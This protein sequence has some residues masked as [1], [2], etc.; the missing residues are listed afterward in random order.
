M[1]VQPDHADKSC[2]NIFPSSAFEVVEFAEDDELYTF[3]GLM[4]E[5][6]PCRAQTPS[7]SSTPTRSAELRTQ[8]VPLLKRGRS[9]RADQFLDSLVRYIT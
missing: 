1:V 7:P 9:V 2:R 5:R 8:N 6:H 4:N 3:D